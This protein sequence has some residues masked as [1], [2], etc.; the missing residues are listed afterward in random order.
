MLVSQSYIRWVLLINKINGASFADQPEVAER[1]NASQLIMNSDEDMEAF[2][3]SLYLTGDVKDALF[4]A[5]G[6]LNMTALNPDAT[7]TGL[8]DAINHMTIEDVIGKE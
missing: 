5:E 8:V 1:V 2:K 6:V 4:T 7:Y 3:K